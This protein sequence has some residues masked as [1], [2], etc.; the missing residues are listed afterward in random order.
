MRAWTSD[1]NEEKLIDSRHFR[2]LRSVHLEH[3]VVNKIWGGEM[4]GKGRC[5]LY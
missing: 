3:L 2:K 5:S 4:R 1:A